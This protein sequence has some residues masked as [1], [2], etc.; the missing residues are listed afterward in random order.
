MSEGPQGAMRMHGVRTWDELHAACVSFTNEWENWPE[1]E[2]KT[3][4]FPNPED[5]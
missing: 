5:R 2:R 3:Y 1:C 4:A